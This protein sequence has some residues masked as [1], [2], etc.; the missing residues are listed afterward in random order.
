MNAMM[1]VGIASICYIS[2]LKWGIILKKLF[3]KNQ[4]KTNQEEKL[5]SVSFRNN[6]PIMN[7]EENIWYLP[8][9]MLCVGTDESES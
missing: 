4:S 9:Q 3:K 5:P 6:E 8:N 1:I 7:S 2:K